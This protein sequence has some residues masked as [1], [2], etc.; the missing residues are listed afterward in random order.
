MSVVIPRNTPIP[1]EKKGSYYRCF[2]NQTSIFFKVYQGERTRSYENHLLGDITISDIPPAPK[3]HIPVTV[4]FQIDVNGI[5]KVS[6]EEKTTGQK[7]EIIMTNDQCSLS[8]QEIE[9]TLKD[10]EKY[11]LEDQEYKKKVLAK[12][13]LENLL[14]KLRKAIKD[15]KIVFKL[16]D[17]DN[18]KMGGYHL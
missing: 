17:A 8:N 12:N 1:T 9:R 2:D 16:A 11:K 3:G 7:N 5:L 6:V 14:Y 13:S 15:G 18:E 4:C 10:A